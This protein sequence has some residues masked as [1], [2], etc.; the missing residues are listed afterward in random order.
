MGH[1]GDKVM[2]CNP[3]ELYSIVTLANINML[4]G[5]AGERLLMITYRSPV[6]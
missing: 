4:F 2:V 1:P 5:D 6:V 3:L